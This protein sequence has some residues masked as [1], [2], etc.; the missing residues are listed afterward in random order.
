MFH[1]AGTSALKIFEKHLVGDCLALLVDIYNRGSCGHCR[2]GAIEVMLK[3][4]TL[5]AY[6][7]EEGLYDSNLDI[8]KLLQ[9]GANNKS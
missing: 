8:R 5:P 9:S 7:Q 3:N 4:N 2:E 1:S 6:I